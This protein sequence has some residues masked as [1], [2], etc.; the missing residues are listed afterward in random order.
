M[1]PSPNLCIISLSHK[2]K[3]HL[4]QEWD[5]GRGGFPPW[6]WHFRH[7]FPMRNSKMGI[8]MMSSQELFQFVFACIIND[9]LVL[10][11]EKIPGNIWVV[12]G[13]TPLSMFDWQ[14]LKGWAPRG[15][16]K[17]RVPF[18]QRLWKYSA[19]KEACFATQHRR[20]CL[21]KFFTYFFSSSL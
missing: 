11:R 8:E 5:G 20:N 3:N 7:A 2:S 17:T 19:R 21:S 12:E 9:L 13:G 1:F 15:R 18:A 10:K 16:H 14:H 4:K 6:I